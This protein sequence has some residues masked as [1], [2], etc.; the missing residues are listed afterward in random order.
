MIDRP[1]P[2]WWLTATE[3]LRINYV[4]FVEYFFST[5][6]FILIFYKN[7]SPKQFQGNQQELSNINYIN[8]IA[9]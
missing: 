8:T 7:Q 5:L 9:T 6:I 4:T 2:S 3:Q 1:A